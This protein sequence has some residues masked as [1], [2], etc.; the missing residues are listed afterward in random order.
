[1]ERP[2]DIGA[3]IE[4][5]ARLDTRWMIHR[6]ARALWP[7]GPAD[8][9]EPGAVEWLRRWRPRGPVDANQIPTCA[10]AAGRCLVCN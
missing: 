1:M 5:I 9:H 2:E 7:G 8:R 6:G 10:C 4:S 3:R